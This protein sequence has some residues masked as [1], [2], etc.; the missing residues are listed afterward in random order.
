MKVATFADRLRILSGE[1]AEADQKLLQL[2]R[3]R[4]VYEEYM[5]LNDLIPSEQRIVEGLSQDRDAL[6]E[7]QVDV[8]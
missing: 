5:R 7:A 4:P 6:A 3:L 2:E 8:S 1:S